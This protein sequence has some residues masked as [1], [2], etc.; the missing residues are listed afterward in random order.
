MF[1]TR[2]EV[3]VG[4]KDGLRIEESVFDQY[5]ES[6]PCSKCREMFLTHREVNEGN[7]DGTKIEESLFDQYKEPSPFTMKQGTPCLY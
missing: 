2:K 3:N 1:L 4:N 5:K 7:K 6:L